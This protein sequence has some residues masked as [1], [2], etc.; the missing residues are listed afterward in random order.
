MAGGA[1]SR[2]DGFGGGM[3]Y[4]WNPNVDVP[5]V[6]PP[7]EGMTSIRDKVRSYCLENPDTGERYEI[8]ALRN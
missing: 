8:T 6:E 3:I 5:L 7:P 1:N 4:D 2:V